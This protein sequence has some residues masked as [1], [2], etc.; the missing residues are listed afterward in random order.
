MLSTRRSIGRAGLILFATLVVAVM[1]AACGSAARILSTVGGSVG[2]APAAAATAAAAGG[3]GNGGNGSTDGQNLIAPGPLLIIKTGTLVL[4]VTGIDA[5]L[6]SATQ[7]I[8]AL[9]GYA[10]G[11]ER[12]ARISAE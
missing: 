10:S 9:S 5:A 1:V 3:N 12:S 2:G 4:Q 8:T 6:A 11:S 7:Q